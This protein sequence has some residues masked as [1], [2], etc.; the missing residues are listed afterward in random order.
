MLLR[1]EHVFD[2]GK[3]IVQSTILASQKPGSTETVTV[4]PADR[5]I[6]IEHTFKQLVGQSLHFCQIGLMRQ[7]HKWSHM[8]QTLWSVSKD[9]SRHLVFVENPMDV[10]QKIR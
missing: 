5:S 1:I 7:T 9:G 4:G 10:L 6:I 3:H 2:F 8:D